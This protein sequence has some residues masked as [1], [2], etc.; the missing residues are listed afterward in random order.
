MLLI[1]KAVNC[2]PGGSATVE[3]ADYDSCVIGV[4]KIYRDPCLLY[5]QSM[6]KDCDEVWEI[7]DAAVN[8]GWE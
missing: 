4:D 1:A 3:N 2:Y 6:V 7:Y 8:A 5:M